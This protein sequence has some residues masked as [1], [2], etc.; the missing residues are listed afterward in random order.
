[1]QSREGLNPFN[2]DNSGKICGEKEKDYDV[3][4]GVYVLR[5]REKA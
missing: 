2:K 1:L 5:I 3:F 4:L